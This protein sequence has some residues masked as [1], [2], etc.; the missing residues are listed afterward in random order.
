MTDRQIYTAFL[1]IGAFGLLIHLTLPF[2]GDEAYFVAWGREFS[3]GVYD[4]PPFADW[5]SASIWRVGEAFGITS[6][7]VLHRIFSSLTGVAC[8]LLI[9]RRHPENLPLLLCIFLSPGLIIFFSMFM[10]DTLLLP[11]LLVFFLSVERGVNAER[12]DWTA[13][14]TGGI[15]FGLA[16]FT[17]YSAGLFYLGIAASLLSYPRGRRFLFGGFVPLSALATVPFLYNLYWGYQN[18]NVNLAFNF[19]FREIFPS[20]VG[21]PQ[22]ALAILLVTGP[23]GVILL[24]H[25]RGLFTRAFLLT[26]ALIFI[27]S[28]QRGYFGINWAAPMGVLAALA[29]LE[30][31][32]KLNLRRIWL[33]SLGFSLLVLVPA[34]GTLV[35][36]EMRWLNPRTAFGEQS[37]PV[38][39]EMELDSDKLAAQIR[40]LSEGRDVAT[41]IY[42]TSSVLER[43]YIDNVTTFTMQVFGRNQDLHT[44][45][46]A[47]D[48]HAF[49]Y[50]PPSLAAGER[51]AEKIFT[52][53]EVAEIEGDFG[54]YYVILGNGFKYESYRQAMILPAIE[55]YYDRGTF[56]YA[57]CYMDKYR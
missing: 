55:K 13:V 21:L 20:V 43:H 25:R 34:T 50:I 54:M 40:N 26:S 39:L 33:W 4:H 17:K 24:R 22:A 7:G 52:S 10:N 44:D 47:L 16:L 56:P 8:F 35:A 5:V 9:W 6:Q 51:L 3:A 32:A 57:A 19:Q 46:A 41:Y 36:L 53:H 29:V 31:S 15:A 18:C 45:F 1:T 42:G 37:Y 30:Q 12:L 2:M 23:V 28:Y 49:A 48:G 38:A 27:V 11:L 14:I